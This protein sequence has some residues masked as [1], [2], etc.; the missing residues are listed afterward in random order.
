M[1]LLLIPLA[2]V[3]VWFLISGRIVD[4]EE[5]LDGCGVNIGKPQR[6]CNSADAQQYAGL[7]PGQPSTLY[8][9]AQELPAVTSASRAIK[10]SESDYSEQSG[11]DDPPVR[12]FATDSLSR[13][14]A[15]QPAS[16]A[17][18]LSCECDFLR[19]L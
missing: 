12:R 10:A 6:T 9:A 8:A 2:G 14:S 15:Q 13:D 3:L 1:S 16:S 7:A 5:D 18:Y 11:R 17:P 19:D 4:P